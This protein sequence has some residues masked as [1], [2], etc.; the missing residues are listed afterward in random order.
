MNAPVPDHYA[1]LGLER[2]CSEADIRAAY[3]FLAKRLHPDVNPR[4]P[5]AMAQIQALNAAY[6]ALGEA[7][8]RR[9]YDAECAQG[10]KGFAGSRS[11]TIKQD[12]HLGLQDFIQ[13]QALTVTVRDAMGTA[14]VEKY[15]LEIPAGTAPGTRFRLKR[16]AA[17]GWVEVRVKARPDF[18][19]K[20]RGSDLCCDLKVSLQRATAGGPESIRGVTGQPIRVLVPRQAGRGQVLRIAGEG[21]PKPR[22]GRGDL[23]VRISYRP[24]VRVAR[25]GSRPA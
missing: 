8:R 17:Q 16:S 25:A 12:V 11:V 18:R 3:R 2:D 23:L 1:T 19:F 21:L 22:G 5:Q 10:E 13:G 14:G 20:V 6:E 24:G 9:A 7:S 15:P 4:S